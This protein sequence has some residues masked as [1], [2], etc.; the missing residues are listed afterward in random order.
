MTDQDFRVPPTEPVWWCATDRRTQVQVRVKHQ[1]WSAARDMAMVELA[2]RLEWP[3]EEE[4]MWQRWDGDDDG[5]G[6]WVT[7]P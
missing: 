2:R 7:L 6:E 5:N 1:F 3:P 4:P